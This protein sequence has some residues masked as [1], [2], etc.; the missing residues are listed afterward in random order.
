MA[1]ERLPHAERPEF[2]VCLT[3]DI[4]E[5]DA[6]IGE[7]LLA[8]RLNALEHPGYAEEIDLHLG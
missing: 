5:L 7:L 1:I 8:S 3:Q 6:L 4:A 2:Q